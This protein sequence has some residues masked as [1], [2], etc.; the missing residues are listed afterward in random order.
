MI[1][2]GD[3]TLTK[4]ES[5]GDY[6]FDITRKSARHFQPIVENYKKP[7]ST[8]CDIVQNKTKGQRV[9]PRAEKLDFRQEE[10]EKLLTTAKSILKPLRA[11][12]VTKKPKRQRRL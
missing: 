11:N 9:H 12:E 5:F 8:F 10:F 7:A 1:Y 2:R 3:F 6:H 4:D